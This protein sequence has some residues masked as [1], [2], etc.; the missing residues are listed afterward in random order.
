MEKVSRILT[1]FG[2]LVVASLLSISI[3]QLCL[4]AVTTVG[5]PMMDFTLPSFQG[6]E[7]RLSDLKGK[8]VMLVFPRGYSG[9]G[10]WCTICD[11]KHAELLDLERTVQ[12]RKKYNLEILVVFPYDR[13]T[14]KAWVEALPGQIEKIRT[15][16]N[17]PDPAKLDDKAKATMEMYRRVFPKDLSI[18]KETL[19]GPFPILIDGDRKLSMGLDLFRTEWGSKVDQNVPTIF[20][21]DKNGIVQFKYFSQTTVDRPSYEYLMR[22]LDWM[23]TE[24]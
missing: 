2:V 5:Q 18:A 3:P 10:S 12:L 17:P 1:A 21:L 4:G 20:I 6:G 7:V 15:V 13:D 23:T 16:K 8:N 22:I 11:Y 24:K 14:V 9:P 19:P